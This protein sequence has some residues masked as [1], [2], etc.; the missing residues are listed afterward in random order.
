MVRSHFPEGYFPYG[1]V[2]FFSGGKLHQEGSCE[3][4]SYPAKRSMDVF[5]F[6]GQTSAR[7]TVRERQHE[8]EGQ[9]RLDA[10]PVQ[11]GRHHR[12]SGRSLKLIPDPRF[13]S[14]GGAA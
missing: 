13:G 7:K 2:R 12:A 10:T 1:E 4:E 11:R 3:F 5:N 9:G 14:W 8:A 6:Q